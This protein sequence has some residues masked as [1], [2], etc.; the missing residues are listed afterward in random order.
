MG[1][2]SLH[3]GV[4]SYR[5]Q[6]KRTIATLLQKFDNVS[7]ARKLLQTWQGV[8]LVYVGPCDERATITPQAKKKLTEHRK[9]ASRFKS[10]PDKSWEY[11]R[12]DW[13]RTVVQ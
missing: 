13:N 8:G 1:E 3:F 12:P 9:N 2:T 11:V 4:F 5:K 7:D 10:V 6:K